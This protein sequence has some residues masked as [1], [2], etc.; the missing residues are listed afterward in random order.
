MSL[1]A[2]HIVFGGWAWLNFFSPE[3]TLAHLIYGISSIVGLG[4]LL[5]YGNYFLK[6]LKTISYL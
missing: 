5:W 6:K 3:G 1:K 2:L 4:A